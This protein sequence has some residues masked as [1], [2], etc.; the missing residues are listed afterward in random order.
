M[1]RVRVGICGLGTV[2]SGVFNLLSTNGT[3][4]TR[5]TGRQIDVSLVGCRRDHPACD[6]STTTVTRDIFDVVRSDDVD[7][8]CE[9]IGGTD[10]ALDL[11][12]EAIAHGKHVVTANKALIAHHGESLFQLASEAGVSLKFEASIAGGI[13]I[14]KAVREGL[15]GNRINWLAGIINGT[16]NFILTEMENAGNRD[17]A[18]VLKEAQDLGYAEADPTFDIEG[19]DAAHKLT[20]LSSIAFGV[21]LNLAALYSEGFSAI[22]VEDI[23][24]ASELGYRIKHL[25]ITTRSEQGVELRVHPTLIEKSRMLAQVNGVMNA[26]MVGSDAAGET[27]YYGAGAGAGPTA[28]SV[29]ADIIDVARSDGQ[30]GGVPEFG[31]IPQALETLPMVPMEETASCHYLRMRLLD[32]PGV[33]ARISTILSQHD[34]SIESMIQ[35]DGKTGTAPVAIITDEIRESAINEAIAELEALAEVD[36]KISR[37]RVESF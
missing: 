24:F 9:L 11:V 3:E 4:I 31:F 2:G 36:G 37:I 10:V 14:V 6:L 35:K 32:K 21:P 8:V 23:R 19:I 7:V 22:T 20:I 12:R 5:K 17:F 28:S 30:S 13:P 15:A 1:N 18:D 16:T 25:G 34:I 29:V 26:V 33:L 27:M